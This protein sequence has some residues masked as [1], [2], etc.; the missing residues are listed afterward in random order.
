MLGFL[1]IYPTSR[2]V[3]GDP[4]TGP[5]QEVVWIGTP[6]YLKVWP[7][8]G[9]ENRAGAIDDAA[10]GNL[11]KQAVAATPPYRARRWGSGTT[12]PALCRLCVVF[13]AGKTRRG[14]LPTSQ[15]PLPL[16]RTANRVDFFWPIESSFSG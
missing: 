12:T 1:A 10:A 4:K 5:A 14:L 2:H 9:T 3:W 13:L 8:P 11:V 7:G 15:T 16:L 6:S